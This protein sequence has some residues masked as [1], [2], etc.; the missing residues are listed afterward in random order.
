MKAYRYCEIEPQFIEV[1]SDL[2]IGRGAIKARLRDFLRVGRGVLPEN[3]HEGKGKG[4]FYTEKEIQRL[5]VA[6]YLSLNTGVSRIKIIEI[7][8]DNDISEAIKSR[9]QFLLSDCVIIDFL[10]LSKMAEGVMASK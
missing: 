9:Q 3:C 7:F 10:R 4:I 8:R 6:L 1:F 5:F 2:G